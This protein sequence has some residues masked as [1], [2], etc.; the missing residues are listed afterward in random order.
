MPHHW[1]NLLN[2]TKDVVHK[3]FTF[4][5]FYEHTNRQVWATD[6][7]RIEISVYVPNARRTVDYSIPV[8][9]SFDV[10]NDK[11]TLPSSYLTTVQIVLSLH[12]VKMISHRN[13]SFN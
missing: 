5:G 8:R 9:L 7:N 2:F 4:F 6:E 13:I 11:G 10:Y 1:S 3:K 12:P